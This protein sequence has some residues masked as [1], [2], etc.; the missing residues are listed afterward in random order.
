M[1]VDECK[2]NSPLP[3]TL[4]LCL[5]INTLGYRVTGVYF[6][7]K[8]PFYITILATVDTQ[9]VLQVI[10]VHVLRYQIVY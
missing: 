9:V 8:S 5:Q 3:V 4:K 7:S 1:C 2:C 6:L 10:I